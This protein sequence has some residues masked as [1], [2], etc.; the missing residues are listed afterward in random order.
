MR[1]NKNEFAGWQFIIC[2]FYFCLRMCPL[3]AQNLTLPKNVNLNWI[4][5]FLWIGLI[6]IYAEF[7]TFDI[8]SFNLVCAWT[9]SSDFR[10]DANDNSGPALMQS[11]EFSCILNQTKS[12]QSFLS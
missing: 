12:K 10:N 8:I 3:S 4:G 5:S 7:I 11:S 6:K 1:V 9:L 2:P